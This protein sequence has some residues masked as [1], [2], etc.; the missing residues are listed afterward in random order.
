MLCRGAGSTPC[1]PRPRHPDLAPPLV[2]TTP[3]SAA[4]GPGP[5]QLWPL[6][7][8]S[9]CA[10]LS[11]GSPSRAT[12]PHSLG[13]FPRC[14]LPPVLAMLS[15][16]C[17]LR[18]HRFDFRRQR[19]SVDSDTA[20]PKPSFL[21]NVRKAKA[22]QQPTSPPPATNPRVHSPHRFREACA[23]ACETLVVFVVRGWLRLWLEEWGVG[24]RETVR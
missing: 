6:N 3:A 14:A 24:Q 16:C 15:A 7:S 9:L 18:L 20:T 2:A 17:M 22:R 12:P 4:C 5:G 8:H 13:S 11:R 21:L 1:R 10:F 23:Y 19:S